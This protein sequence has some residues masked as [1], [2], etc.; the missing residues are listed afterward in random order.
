MKVRVIKDYKEYRKGQTYDV[1]PN[2]AHDL[3]DSGV[4]RVDRMFDSYK[5]ASVR[6]KRG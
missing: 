5:T 3:I 6:K 2:I 1:T 4:A